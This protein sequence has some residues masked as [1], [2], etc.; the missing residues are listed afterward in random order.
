MEKRKM[1]SVFKVI[2]NSIMLQRG[3]TVV[4]TLLVGWLVLKA[5]RK[6]LGVLLEK[7]GLDKAAFSFV[8]HVFA[9][10]VFVV[11]VLSVFNELG[12]DISSFLTVFA[13]LSAAVALALKDSLSNVAGGIIIMF[14]RP[15]K[16]GEFISVGDHSG[17]VDSIDLMHTVIHTYDN[18][19]V[20]IPNGQITS[21]S[22]VNFSSRPTRRV[23]IKIGIGYDSDIDRARAVMLKLAA[24]DPRIFADP[25]P[26]CVLT[27][28]ADSA[29]ILTLRAWTS[30][31]AYWNVFNDYMLALKPAFDAKGISIA[32]PQM[33]VHLD[34]RLSEVNDK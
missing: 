1:D 14:T 5:G 17:L 24:D 12:M 3:I 7:A 10:V 4:L 11:V 34:G 20:I 32:Y 33:D 29:I 13:A 26:V 30:T 16:S 8:N 19:S 21:S 2:E 18:K 22:I 27:E 6:Y 9:I 31:G 25:A 28:Y 15:F 23:D